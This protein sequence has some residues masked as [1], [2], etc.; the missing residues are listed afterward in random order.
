VKELIDL[1]N[2]ENAGTF[3]PLEDPIGIEEA[4]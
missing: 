4:D 2:P 1:R 3:R